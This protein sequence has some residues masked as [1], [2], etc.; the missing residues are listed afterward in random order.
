MAVSVGI[1]SIGD[2][3]LGIARLLQAH[4]YRVLTVTAGRSQDTINRI[5]AA[6]IEAL[7]T[8]QDLVVQSDYILSIVPPRDAL[9]TAQRVVEATQHVDTLRRRSERESASKKPYFFDLNAISPRSAREIAAL[10]S[11]TTSE[12][13]TIAY[14]L[15]GGIIGGPPSLDAVGQTWKKPSLVLSGSVPLPGT[16]AALAETLN[17]KIVGPKIGSA[18]ALKLSFASLTKGLTALTVLSFSTAHSEAVLP[19][20]LEHLNEYSPKTAAL[21]TGGIAAMPPKAYRWVEEMR[22]I[23]EAF[24]TEGHWDGVGSSVYG[25]FAEIYRGIAED[26]ILGQEKVG[27]R[28]RGTTAEDVA[29]IV[30]AA[31][32]HP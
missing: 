20:L 3:G 12:D 10:F 32:S 2:M 6:S 14:F 9:A 7:S 8:D 23:G 25:A 15:D 24:D 13:D 28:R 31:K 19:E 29:A 17:M 5:K 26:T 11:P 16:F 27:Q 22:G 30:A 21:S 1:L 4:S 18:S